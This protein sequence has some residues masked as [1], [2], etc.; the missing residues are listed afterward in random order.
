MRGG[1]DLTSGEGRTSPIFLSQF[2]E[3]NEVSTG[4]GS[5]RVGT[6]ASG[7]Q[8]NKRSMSSPA[9]RRRAYRPVAIAPGTDSSW[10]V[11]T[12]P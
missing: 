9:R 8:F 4:S 3:C 12:A 10:R 6:H 11:E 7:V 2:F 1:F 5:D